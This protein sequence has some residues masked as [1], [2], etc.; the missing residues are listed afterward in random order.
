M[1]KKTDYSP[2]LCIMTPQTIMR[3]RDCGLSS[4]RQGNGG[5]TGNENNSKWLESE[6]CCLSSYR[7]SELLFHYLPSRKS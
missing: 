7:L 6:H 3:P 1:A 5:K 4:H 2:G